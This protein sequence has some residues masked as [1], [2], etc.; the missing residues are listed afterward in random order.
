M[1]EV[2]VASEGQQLQPVLLNLSKSLGRSMRTINEYWE[3]ISVGGLGP[4]Y[5]KHGIIKVRRSGRK[6]FFLNGKVPKV[7]QP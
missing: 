2:L 5:E 7:P 4:I 1:T 6:G 3:V